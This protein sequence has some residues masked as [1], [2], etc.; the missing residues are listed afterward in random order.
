MQRLVNALFE[1]GEHQWTHNPS[2][3][4]RANMPATSFGSPGT[5]GPVSER[6]GKVLKEN[7]LVV[8]V[9]DP[10][11]K[12]F[13]CFCPKSYAFLVSFF[14]NMLYASRIYV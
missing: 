10:K 6:G 11:S 7:W 4:A 1:I 14:P 13:L 9:V 5:L 3:N 2:V 12:D 8:V